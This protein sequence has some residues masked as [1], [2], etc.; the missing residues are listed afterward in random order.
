MYI[1]RK[2]IYGDTEVFLQWRAIIRIDTK[3][4]LLFFMLVILSNRHQK[5][6]FWCQLLKT[7]S[8]KNS[9]RPK[10][11]LLCDFTFLKSNGEADIFTKG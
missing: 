11:Q 3:N 8:T 2:M 1:S 6:Y 9:F 10:I 7:V 5:Y 4:E